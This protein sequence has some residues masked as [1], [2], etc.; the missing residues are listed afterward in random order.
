MSRPGTQPPVAAVATRTLALLALLFAALTAACA[1]DALPVDLGAWS[2][3]VV[4]DVEDYGCPVLYNAASRRCTFPGRLGLDLDGSGGSFSQV[5]NVYRESVAYLPGDRDHWPLEVLVDDR[6]AAVIAR[7]GRPT[8]VL[9][10]GRHVIGG[11]FRWQR[12]PESL[13]VPP[14]S[15]LVALRLGGSGVAQADIRNGQLW[16]S[17]SRAQTDAAHRVE[18]RVFRKITD[19]V[20]LA[21][22]TRIELD[23]SGEQREL[24]LSGALP[25]GFEPVVV[26]SRLPARLDENGRLLLK[27]RAGRWVV[28]VDSRL[29]RETLALELDGFPAPWPASEL[30]VFEARPQLR[31]LRVTSPVSIDASQSALPQDW[32]RLPAYRMQPGTALVFEQIRRGDPEPEP[33]QLVLRRELWLDAGGAGYTVSDHISGTLSRGWRINAGAGLAPGQVSLDGQPQ[34]ITR[35]GDGGIGIEVRKGNIDLAAD[36]R[37]EDAVRHLSAVGWDHDFSN[38]SASINV[39]PGYRVLAITGADH[40]PATWLSRWTLL[41]FFIVLVSSIALSRLHGLR[42]GAVGLVGLV[43]LWHEP[44]APAYIW[45]NLIATLALM[46]AARNTRLYPLARNY[47]AL[48]AL[49][50][51]LLALPFMVGQVREGI[52]PQLEQPWLAMGGPS[53][54]G[55]PAT[56]QAPPAAQKSLSRALTDSV[57]DRMAGIASRDEPYQAAPAGELEK[58]V[59][60]PGARLQTGPGLPQWRWRSYPVT[61]N[62]PVQKDQRLS[63]YLVG[64]FFNLLLNLFR[65]AVVALL[66]WKLIRAPA[67]EWL[68]TL[69][70]GAAGTAVALLAVGALSA[71]DP[72]QAAFPPQALL[73]ALK[74]RLLEPADCLP[75]CAELERLAIR[76]DPE[77]ARFTLRVHAAE[78]LALPLP[79]PLNDWMPSGV[80]VDGTPADA[81][82]R[83]SNALLWLYVEAGVHDVAVQGRVAQL[84]AL[85]L[86]LP[87][88]PH[89]L[90]LALEG[91]SRDGTDALVPAPRSLT[92]TREQPDG[93]AQRFDTPSR[94]PVFA[95]IT[96]QLRL[97]LDWRLVTTVQL[98][99]GTALPAVLRIPLLDGEAVVTD[100]IKVEDD[101]AIVSLSETSRS[102]SWSSTLAQHEHLSLTAARDRPWSE[103]WSVEIAPIWNVRFSGIPVVYHQQAD[104]AWHPQW[105]PWPGEQVQLTVTRPQAI[106]GRTR[107]IDS[108]LLTLTPGR[109]ATAAELSFTLRSSLGQQHTV[110]LPED[111]RLESVSID[112]RAVPIRQDGRRVNLPLKPGNQNIAL[113]W[114]QPRGIGWRFASP[115]VGLGA[116]SVNA[117]IVIR[118]GHDRWVLLTGGIRQGPAV[119]FWGVLIVIVLIALVLGRVRDTPLNTGSWILLGIGLSTVTPFIA[120]LIAAW[121]F[122]L[123]ARGRSTGPADAARFDALQIALVLLTFIAMAA[124]FGAVSN[125]LLGNPEMQIAGNGS[126]HTLLN[127]YQDRIGDTLPQAWVISVPVLAYRFLMLAWSMWMAFALIE[128]LKWGWG[129]DRLWIPL[130]KAARSPPD[131]AAGG[132]DG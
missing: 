101:N 94:I 60:D 34:L 68:S 65:V 15:G 41:D 57:G 119:L 110:T 93:G 84:R 9:D 12:L 44:G 106:E 31:L 125:G 1:D 30:W 39:P 91:W 33:D 56:P 92:F 86:D 35:T 52:F 36:S 20:P 115:A 23:V 58:L 100:D 55:Q 126:S 111:A 59:Q 129:C 77:Q 71:P 97:G 99:S 90:E 11:S 102:L 98:E 26:R 49:A 29:N 48:S 117:R 8:L 75:H 121:I 16:L 25:R 54:G 6:P 3:W 22:T 132:V 120:L 123:Y 130:R 45:L 43:A 81:L 128:W 51:L 69:R 62:G 66:A 32:K 82:F 80:E 109:R 27:L 17:E 122:A 42:W 131:Q 61:W 73:S 79:V 87:L 28:D 88:P 47:L 127:W 78:N 19:Q 13:A 89:A 72:A 95:H 4:R 114:Q 7:G 5:L 107:T 85:R 96:R 2:G 112:G 10:D 37:I 38:V 118:P 76:L 63:V 104:G 103:T 40:S 21:V 64:P 24:G 53:P 116:P 18:L 14:E 124:L 74:E 108:S 83:D 46:R 50:L 70:S 113:R 67:N 105:R